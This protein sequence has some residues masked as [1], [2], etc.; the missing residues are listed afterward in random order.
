MDG[1]AITPSYSG[2]AIHQLLYSILSGMIT[3]NGREQPID[4]SGLGG[5]RLV[6]PQPFPQ[7][8]STNVPFPSN[9]GSNG[10]QK[11]IRYLKTAIEELHFNVT[12]GMLTIPNLI[13]LQNTTSTASTSNIENIWEY[14]WIPLAAA[15]GGCA[16]VNIFAIMIGIA[17]IVNSDGVG[18]NRSGV[19]RILMTTRNRTLDTIIGDRGRGDDDM[20]EEVEDTRVRF[21]SL[22][23]RGSQEGLLAFGVEQE[24]AEWK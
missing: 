17:A 19:L 14:N 8:N 11:P 15:Y 10:I 4:T 24:I 18:I 3:L 20:Q 13:Y 16:A 9:P 22:T 7:P 21:G 12:V 5:T 23:R 2:Y 6:E 1:S